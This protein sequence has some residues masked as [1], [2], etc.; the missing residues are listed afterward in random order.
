MSY[1]DADFY[2]TVYHGL[3]IPDEDEL[4]ALID[5]A[6]SLIDELTGLQLAMAGGIESYFSKYAPA[7]SAILIDKVKTAVAC[8]VEYLYSNGGLITASGMNGGGFSIGGFSY[9]PAS[10]SGAAGAR[11]DSRFAPSV[12]GLLEQTGLMYRGLGVRL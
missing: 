5:R 9:S 3:E 4:N 6:S 12:I 10:Q 1:I 8:E 11:M 2:N 7:V